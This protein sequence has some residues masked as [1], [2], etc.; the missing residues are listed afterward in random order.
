MENQDE[1]K[2]KNFINDTTS[3]IT[4]ELAVIKEFGPG[5]VTGAADDDPSGIATYTIAGAQLGTRLLWIS[6]FTWPLMA[7]VQIMCAQVAI[8]TGKGLVQNLRAKMHPFLVILCILGLLVANIFNIVA[9]LG[10]I[11][12]ALSL[13]S[14]VPATWFILPTAILI[15]LA[16][17]FL[18]YRQISRLLIWLTICLFS[19]V[20]TVLKTSPNWG[21]VLKQAITPSIPQ[22]HEEWQTI[23]AILGTTISPYLFFWQASQEIEE[24]KS[25][26]K[27]GIHISFKDMMKI[28]RA[29]VRVG[30]FISQ[31]IMFFIILAAA[32][33]LFKAGIH[34][35]TTTKE[36]AQALEP[37]LGANAA[38]IYTL[39]IIGVGLLAIPTLAGSAAFALTD[40]LNIKNGLDTKWQQSKV[41][42]G[43]IILATLGS[44]L[45][46]MGS[47]DPMKA[48]FWSA[49]VN[50]CIAPPLIFGILFIASDHKLMNG[51][52]LSLFSRIIIGFT[53]VLM[54]GCAF[55]LFL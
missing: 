44:A 49:I 26:E 12:D 29:D 34:N 43:V 16:M 42:Y 18:S 22:S 2:P 13:V 37:L 9:D 40:F 20:L 25:K 1:S 4:K 27:L 50:G 48:L 38:L 36:A 51:N 53:A 3:L 23:V 52:S 11:A 21:E 19:Y 8:A 32:N 24:I 6:W 14:G 47:F 39:G 28:R 17:V 15:T 5:I 33:S 54:T 35:I 46:A 31:I 41:F 55:T 30:T 45:L 7:S 10:A